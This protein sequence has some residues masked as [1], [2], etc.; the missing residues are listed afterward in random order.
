MKATKGEKE[1]DLMKGLQ[2][3]EVLR[4]TLLLELCKKEE[5]EKKV[6]EH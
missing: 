2:D 1:L 4:Q 3:K 5:S 6:A